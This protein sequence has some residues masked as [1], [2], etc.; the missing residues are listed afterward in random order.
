V[1][2]GEPG[3]DTAVVIGAGA[4]EL[5]VAH[6]LAR[7]GR[8]AVLLAPAADDAPLG[9]GW[10]PAPIMRALGLSERSLEV[11][12]P[13][14]WVVAPL[15]DG[16]R[17]ELRQ[18]PARSAESIRR[19]SPRDA[20][21][22]PAF[23]ARMARLAR[24]LEAI[25]VA[26]PPDPLATGRRDL[27]Q[28]GGLALRARRLGRE[29]LEDLLRIVPMPVADL[30]DDWFES[31]A[32]KGVLGAAAVMHLAQG[33]RSG[34]TAFGLLHRH[35]GS[36]PGVFRPPRSSF[37]RAV[38][39]LPGIQIR[40]GAEVARIAVRDARATGVVLA[41]GEEI[42]ASVVV[43]GADAHRT[44]LELVD[45][46]LL[47]PALVRA[48]RAIRAR[49]VVARATLAL[50]RAPG[51]TTIALAPSLDDLER[52][53]DDAKHGRVS[54]APWLEA[55]RDGAKVEVH[56]QYA[57]YA[58]AGGDWD[59]ARRDALGDLL[60]R[61]VAPHLGGAAIVERRVRTPV[62]LERD[63]GWPEG[64]ANQAE[65]ALDQLL[66][67]RPV[68]ALARY[69]TPIGGLY[70]CGTGQHPGAGVAGASGANAARVILLDGAF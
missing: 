24:L 46:G 3:R 18:D 61:A 16:G 69:R 64:Q 51:F 37:R 53:Y 11:V 7:A 54:R 29:G 41:S 36:P 34:G 57:P 4:N 40:A 68:P 20:A 21:K 67:M 70:L 2:G 13:D 45:P 22:W 63:Y 44:L 56:V 6:L 17:L 58:L 10:V 59:D 12:R 27:A 42:A 35:V 65:L 9:T 43:S 47:D 1:N 14:P 32:L 38:A 8:R 55:T 48:V 19:L 60:E 52:A 15:P 50:D 28:L 39:G 25:Y 30:L 62:D 33:P 23:C 26:P 5:V 66:W 31:D 49:G